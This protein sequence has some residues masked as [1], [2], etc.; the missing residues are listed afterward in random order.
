MADQFVGEIRAVSFN[1]APFGWALC[2]GQI[3]PISQ[4]T[5]LFSL[6]GTFYGGNG[7]SNFALPNLQ[8]LAPMSQGNGP[9]L[10]QRIIGETGGEPNVTLLLSQIPAHSHNAMNAPASTTG[11]PATN[12]VFGGGG[13]GKADAYAPAPGSPALMNPL[14]VTTVGGSLPHNNMPPYLVLNFV[15][16]L[17]GI[18]PSRG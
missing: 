11:T 14:A 13:R 3:L 12:T 10:T 2:N 7:T 4:N 6:L 16:A 18:F 5:A 8:G 17:Q 1:F 9:G 15:I